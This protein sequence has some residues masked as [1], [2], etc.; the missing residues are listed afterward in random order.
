MMVFTVLRA[1]WVPIYHD[2]ALSYIHT[3]Y[4]GWWDIL[5]FHNA[6]SNNHLLNSLLIKFT[7]SV[8]VPNELS[9]RLPN[10]LAHLAY[11]WGTYRLS[12][13]RVDVFLLFNLNPFAV[14]YFSQARG[15]GL[16]LGFL[17]LAMA[18]ASERKSALKMTVWL[19]LAALSNFTFL[20][21]LIALVGMWIFFERKRWRRDWHA[22]G[23]LAV[24]WLIAAGP[25]KYLRDNGEL[26]Y[27]GKTGFLADT[28]NSL[29]GYSF[30]KPGLYPV[31]LH[32]GTLA[33]VFVGVLTALMVVAFLRQP[34]IFTGTFLLTVLGVI[35]HHFLSGVLYP[36]DRTALFFVP[37]F[38]AGA[39]SAWEQEVRWPQ[40]RKWGMILAA[41]FLALH[42]VRVVDFESAVSTVYD[43]DT[44]K[45]VRELERVHAE[46]GKPILLD[47]SHN[48]GPALDFYRRTLGLN[49]L[50]LEWQ[51]DTQLGG[52]APETMR[53]FYGSEEDLKPRTAESYS[54]RYP[55][56]E[57]RLYRLKSN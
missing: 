13:G 5:T 1:V 26:Y 35:S 20:Y 39:I 38:T 40:V 3:L 23:V 7:T 57:A 30:Y 53:F 8:F 32:L 50:M 9:V 34:K 2:E 22:F 31:F 16:A 52:L 56:S 47:A 19:A 55:Y 18:E 27:G 14:T 45:V 24:F 43:A 33:I 29:I 36:I 21:P 15:Y 37:L 49:W 44:K 17:A 12:R 4:Y 11:L 28:V 6:S 10:I 25:I 51:R 41:V 42:F 46:S 54:S 48:F